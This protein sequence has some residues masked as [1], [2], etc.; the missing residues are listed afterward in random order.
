MRWRGRAARVRGRLV[1]LGGGGDCDARGESGAGEGAAVTASGG[2]GLRLGAIV[3][4]GV[5]KSNF[6]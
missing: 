1:R 5:V 2:G 4:V 6:R 3:R